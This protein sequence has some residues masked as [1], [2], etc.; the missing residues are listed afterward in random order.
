[1]SILSNASMDGTISFS[2]LIIVYLHTLN[3]CTMYVCIAHTLLFSVIMLLQS[4]VNLKTKCYNII[5]L[6]F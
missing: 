4:F 5:S 3:A 6:K 2:R 1:M